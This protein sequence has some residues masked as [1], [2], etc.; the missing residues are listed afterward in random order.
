MAHRGR[1]D[2]AAAEHSGKRERGRQRG[3]RHGSAAGDLRGRERGEPGVAARAG[4]GVDPRAAGAGR[5]A[6]A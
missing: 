3:H 6:G 4:G 1:V 2:R 5:A